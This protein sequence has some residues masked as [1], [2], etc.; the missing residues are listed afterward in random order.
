MRIVRYHLPA[1]LAIVLLAGSAQAQT[2][3]AANVPARL[4]VLK[5]LTL[6]GQQELDFGTILLAP[7]TWSNS[8]VTVSQAGV[9][10]CTA[11]ITCSGTV[12]AARFSVTGTNNQ[13]A[14]IT[15]PNVTLINA[16]DSTQRLTMTAQAPATIS[17]PNSG[18]SGTTF[19]VGGTVT[20]SSTT[21]DGVYTGT[22][23]V[24]VDYQ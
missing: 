14:V 12:K 11:P 17:L 21:A 2:R 3:A 1:T 22:L 16:V 10:T 4:S 19:S 24:T 20:V 7:G 5:P 13:T 23:E 15:V 9:R 8:T 18:N 6:A